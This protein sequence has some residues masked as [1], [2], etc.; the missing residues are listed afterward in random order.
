M[1]RVKR[2]TRGIAR[3]KKVM[4]L[5]KGFRNGRGNLYRTAREAVNKAMVHSYRDR[6]T[7]KRDFRRLWITR[8][9][10]ASRNEGLTYSRFMKGLNLSG[11]S[12]DRKILADLAVREP[13]TFKAIVTSAKNSLSEA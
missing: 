12:L 7:R 4:K 6:R 2:G 3:R 10:A 9:N 8:I 5:A 11:I 13:E 1:T